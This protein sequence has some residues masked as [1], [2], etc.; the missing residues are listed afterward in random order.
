MKY[1]GAVIGVGLGQVWGG[2]GLGT[3]LFA[4]AG[5]AVGGVLEYL[6]GIE[7]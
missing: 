2:D 3:L 1:F 6:L 4:S 7:E 5:F